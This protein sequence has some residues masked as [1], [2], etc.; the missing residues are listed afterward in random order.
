MTWKPKVRLRTQ[1]MFGI[2]YW[3]DMVFVC[4]GP[5]ELVW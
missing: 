4:I 5:I 1:F 2:E 3:Y